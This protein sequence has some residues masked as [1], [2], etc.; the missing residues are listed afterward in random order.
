M[1]IA[2][3]FFRSVFHRGERAAFA[4]PPA[5]QFRVTRLDSPA[6]KPI[7]SP[8]FCGGTSSEEER[9]ARSWEELSR[10]VALA[11][12]RS[13]SCRSASF[14]EEPRRILSF[15]R[16]LAANFRAD[17]AKKAESEDFFAPLFALRGLNVEERARY[18]AGGK[19][20]GR[21]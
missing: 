12:R 8:V 16:G 21:L 2:H 18:R 6:A 19:D 15:S 11:D 20:S 4:V 13:R 9:R 14:G 3:N 5:K 1:S 7:S 17:P 10:I